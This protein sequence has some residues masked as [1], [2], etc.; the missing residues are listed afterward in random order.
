[1]REI[2]GESVLVSVGNGVAD[3]CGI[4]KLND[5]AKVIWSA[6]QNGTSQEEL[7]Q[8]LVNTFHITENQ[9]KKDVAQS[10]EL[11]LNKRMITCE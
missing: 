4:V 1:M 10:L 7:I 3:F 11:L 2:A 5:S 9:A 6:L 8:A